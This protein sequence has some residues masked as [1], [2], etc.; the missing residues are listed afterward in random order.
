MIENYHPEVHIEENKDQS[1]MEIDDD[2]FDQMINKSYS[3]RDDDI[4]MSYEDNNSDD[5]L[6][7]LPQTDDVCNGMKVRTKVK[8]NFQK[9]VRSRKERVRKS[10]INRIGN[11]RS[12]HI[13]IH[14]RNTELLRVGN[15]HITMH[16][17]P[18]DVDDD[19]SRDTGRGQHQ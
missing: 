4:N 11:P 9:L 14:E 3:W 8:F 13:T 12:D 1:D 7:R 10:F 5:H 16:E 6:M 19:M 17:G 15:A 18:I 2:T